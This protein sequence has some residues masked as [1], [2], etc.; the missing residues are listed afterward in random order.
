MTISVSVYK[1]KST[2][3]LISCKIASYP[4]HVLT[5]SSILINH[6]PWVF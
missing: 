3:S 1:D 5:Q 2:F 4:L 6:C